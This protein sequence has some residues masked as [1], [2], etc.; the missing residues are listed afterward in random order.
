MTIQD[1]LK[2]KHILVFGIGRQ[3]GGL[4]DANYLA[5]RGYQVKATDMQSASELG[6]DL[7]AYAPGLE[8]SLG[9]HQE[10]DIDW[11]DLIIK[12][13]AVPDD[14]PLIL[15]ALSNGADVYTSISL[16]VKYAPL[17]TI[18]ITG[19]RGKTTTTTLIYKILEAAYPGKILLGGNIPGHSAL[20]M[21]AQCAGKV[22]AV[23][24]LS[25]FQLHSFHDQQVSPDYSVVTNL[26]PDHLNRYVDMDSYRHDKEA[27]VR[28][29]VPPG[30]TVYNQENDGSVQIAT[31]SPVTK[32]PFKRTLARSYK[33][34]LLG[35]HNQSNLSA[36][37]TLCK[38]LG[39]TDNVIKK[40]IEHFSG[41]A[42]R[43]EQIR[44]LRGIAFVNDTTATTPIAAK[45]ALTSIKGGIILICGGESK[46]LPQD[47]LIQEII[48]ND[49]VKKIVLLG[50][51]NLVDFTETL[52]RVCPDK[53]LGQVQSMSEAVNLAY[54]VSSVGDTIL[55]SPGFSS[56]DLFK[57]EFDRGEQF[58]R[59]VQ[60]LK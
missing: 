21:F 16:F 6:Y 14:H 39:I 41:V 8:L 60:A 10:S 4:G 53:I 5:E 24:E 50:S 51:L 59:A 33:T 30:F 36:A 3:G 25:S 56:F 22:Y 1:Y 38:K 57:N 29:Q 45:A 31:S 12:N 58:N 42:Y 32:Y 54:S 37:I 40:T 15:R 19:T 44:T 52:R 26:Y 35:E 55:L 11:A 18:G 9:G 17:K 47:D 46:K 48:N 28:Y 7:S 13:P 34:K 49:H 20:S 23:L 43:L 2:G 27:I